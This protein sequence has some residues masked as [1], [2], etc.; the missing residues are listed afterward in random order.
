MLQD[1]TL[2]EVWCETEDDLTLLWQT[3]DGLVVELVQ[4]KANELKQLWSIALLCEGAAKSIIAKS[5]A[6]DRCSEPC[7]FRVVTRVDIHPDLH[8]LRLER[9]HA[10][11]CLG[12]PAVRALHQEVLKSLGDML[13][14]R[15][16]SASHW[17]ADAVWDGGDSEDAIVAKNRWQL[18]EHLEASGEF[19]FADQH[20]ELY[21]RVLRHVQQAAFPKWK[22]GPEKKKLLRAP[23][24]EWLKET[25][26]QI[27]GYAPTR[28]GRNLERKMRDAQLP[29]AHT[30]NADR[31]RRE[32]RM[33][34]TEPK[35]QHDDDI[36][37]A[38]LEVV[39]TM[40]HL[41][42][43]LDAGNVA[44]DG[45]RFHARCL[46]ALQSIRS[47]FPQVSASFLQG[48][49]YTAADRCRH[50]FAPARP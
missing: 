41:L 34:Q 49:M 16:R 35:Y 31:L 40:Q 1:P 5:L 25:I 45:V 9:S 17:L 11:R 15:G 3:D 37:T 13:S 4:V 18:H 12:N 28:A 48:A 14:P 47:G 8:L 20:K 33:R 42:S 29:A 36:R 2:V 21:E 7:R 6:H 30:E 44:D 32:F 27:R 38:E 43:D 19:L 26:Y 10:A 22:D 23:F 50:R 46:G 24:E 39:A